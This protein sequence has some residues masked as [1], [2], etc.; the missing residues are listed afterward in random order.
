MVNLTTSHCTMQNPRRITSTISLG[1]PI[2]TR[3]H[4]I[5]GSGSTNF[6]QTGDVDRDVEIVKIW[7]EEE[8]QAEAAGIKAP[9]AK[10]HHHVGTSAPRPKRRAVLPSRY[11]E[12]DEIVVKPL[13]RRKEGN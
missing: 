4:S 2:Q 8:L 1:E 10:R 11:R 12:E 5:S 6:T 3:N 13:R 7:T 9:A